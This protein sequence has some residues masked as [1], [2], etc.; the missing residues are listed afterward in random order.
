MYEE[1]KAR[2]R[3]FNEWR[4]SAD[5]S[6]PSPKQIGEDINASIEAIEQLERQLAERDAEIAKY[7][8]APV[9]ACVVKSTDEDGD[10][11]QEVCFSAAVYHYHMFSEDDIVY[12][13]I[14]KPVEQ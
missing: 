8:D 9:V 5:F 2:L 11:C 13:L 12:D 3:A 10:A 6:I 7:R 1:L 4:R 14:V